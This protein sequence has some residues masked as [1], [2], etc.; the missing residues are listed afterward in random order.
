MLVPHSSPG[1]PARPG[2]GAADVVVPHGPGE[3]V[4]LAGLILALAVIVGGIWWVRRRW[5]RT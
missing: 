1:P 5:K 2:P 4:V 3:A